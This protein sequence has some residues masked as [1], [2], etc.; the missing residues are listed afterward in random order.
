MSE[1]L[2]IKR[3]ELENPA[4]VFV[5]IAGLRD[6]AKRHRAAY[7][8]TVKDMD[9]LCQQLRGVELL[10]TGRVR[11]RNGT[12][13]YRDDPRSQVERLHVRVGTARIETFESYG[14]LIARELPFINFFAWTI[15]GNESISAWLGFDDFG[16]T[17]EVVM[18]DLVQVQA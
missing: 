16:V 4:E 11:G 17:A 5:G 8:E 7:Q 6:Q 12:S 13:L 3:S 10:I 9:Q 18:I 2:P 15:E 1:S 14:N